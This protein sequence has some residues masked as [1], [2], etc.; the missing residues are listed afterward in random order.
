MARQKIAKPTGLVVEC[1]HCDRENVIYQHDLDE[2]D[3]TCQ[4]A[5]C[6]K[7]FATCTISDFQE[8]LLK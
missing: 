7:S 8:Y 4:Y 3:F 1:P 2:I 6:E 5:D